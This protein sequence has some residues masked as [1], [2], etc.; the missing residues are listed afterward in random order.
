[1]SGGEGEGNIPCLITRKYFDSATSTDFSTSLSYLALETRANN[2]MV[3][4]AIYESQ[5][6]VRS[7]NREILLEILMDFFELEISRLEIL[8]L[9]LF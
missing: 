9:K 7:R 1:M 3:G 2:I 6:L 8:N 4:W 5:P